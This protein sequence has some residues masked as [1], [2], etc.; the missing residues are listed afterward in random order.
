[1]DFAVDCNYVAEQMPRWVDELGRQT[2][3]QLVAI[4]ESFEICR[5]TSHT[6]LFHSLF[7]GTHPMPPQRPDSAGLR[8]QVTTGIR[9]ESCGGELAEGAVSP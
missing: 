2:S 4:S 1:M 7:E 6:S 3:E 9:K 5:R 8:S